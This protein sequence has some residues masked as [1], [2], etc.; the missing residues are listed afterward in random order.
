[1]D[2]DITHGTLSME[3]GASFAGQIKRLQQPVGGSG[4]SGSGTSAGAA[5]SS[6][7][8]SSSFGSGTP[9]KPY[10]P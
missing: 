1:V 8:A 3:A 2:G 7:S 5:S 10:N 6:T 4:S 9:A